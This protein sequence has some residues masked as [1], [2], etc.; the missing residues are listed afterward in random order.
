[1]IDGKSSYLL[2]ERVG[3]IKT[4]TDL[5]QCINFIL[6]SHLLCKSVSISISDLREYSNLNNE[7]RYSV[8]G[9]PKKKKGELRTIS[10]P[11][12]RLK[13][14]LK[15][16]NL[17]LSSCYRPPRFVTGFVYSTSVVD[18][19]RFHVG[20]E[21]VLNIDLK[22]FFDTIPPDSIVCR[23]MRTPFSFPHSIAETIVMLS[24]LYSSE[25]NR[26]VLAQGSPLSPV[27]SNIF[28]EALDT[29]LYSLSL[30]NN[31][32]FSRY[33]DDITF[34]SNEAIIAPGT[35]FFNS[36]VNS[37][38]TNGL[39][40]NKD[41]VRLQNNHYR[42]SV[43]GL[44]VNEKVN[45][46]RAYIKDIRNLLYI[47]NRY[48]SQSAYL[49]FSKHYQKCFPQVGR[50][51]IPNFVEYLRGKINYLG[52]VKGKD[53]P[54]F[55][56]FKTQFDSL[57]ISKG[58]KAF[59]MET[60]RTVARFEK[61]RWPLVFKFDVPR[62]NKYGKQYY[63]IDYPVPGGEIL[64][65][66]KIAKYV[67]IKSPSIPN[68]LRDDCS[69]HRVYSNDGVKWILS[70][71]RQ[72][73][74]MG[75]IAEALKAE[76]ESRIEEMN[77]NDEGF[78]R[79]DER[80]SP[81]DEAQFAYLVEGENSFWGDYGFMT[82]YKYFYC[83]SLDKAKRAMAAYFKET[84]KKNLNLSGLSDD[85]CFGGIEYRP[86]DDYSWSCRVIRLK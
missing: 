64:V 70:E 9:I 80:L 26:P 27:L 35:P 32:T 52:L 86:C 45:V 23:L 59:C 41:K 38:Q 72:S 61:G 24:C 48:G 73:N 17:L 28:C 74:I 20:K 62:T 66:P 51:T 14:I 21:Y 11:V 68:I 65:S 2:K 63:A 5:V 56:R 46:S 18:N 8:F 7:D 6:R 58:F 4:D 44:V 85:A 79:T 78:I 55:I 29:D 75:D 43:T 76:R 34:S 42:Q 81:S 30:Q 53:D 50:K 22:N 15:A 31:A 84:A 19:A 1:M 57:V 13:L 49:G 54:I 10:A 12:D 33:A 77:A 37:I 60:Y 47:W 39:L 40:L 82:I 3:T 83:D 67:E 25:Y 36:V 71:R 16:L 69:I